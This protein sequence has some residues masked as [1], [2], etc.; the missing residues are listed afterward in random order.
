MPIKRYNFRSSRR[1]T[2]RNTRRSK[3]NV[4]TTSSR[5]VSSGTW[6]PSTTYS[7]TRFNMHRK[8][9]NAKIASFRMINQQVSGP[10]K[11]TAFS[12]STT[13]KWIKL[14]NNGA[15]VFKFTNAQFSQKFGKI[16]TKNNT[17]SFSGSPN[18]ALKSLQRMFGGG[19][20]AVTRG[21]ANSWLIAATPTVN[22]AP[23]SNY[24]F[25]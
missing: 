24:S 9:L 18:V 5:T 23:F 15:F 8:D 22:K 13:N 1:A 17:K 11:V 25:K 7:P 16:V 14:V 12:P 20:K 10:G 2:S 19:I 4:R 3:R 21:K 6:T